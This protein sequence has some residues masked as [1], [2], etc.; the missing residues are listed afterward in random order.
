MFHNATLSFLSPDSFDNIVCNDFFLS[1]RE[2]ENSIILGIEL[3]SPDITAFSFSDLTLSMFDVI[4][5]RSGIV[6]SLPS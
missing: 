2:S 4:P 5:S 6:I 3:I 1:P